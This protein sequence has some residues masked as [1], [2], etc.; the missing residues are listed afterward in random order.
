MRCL[1]CHQET[2]QGYWDLPGGF[3]CALCTLVLHRIRV[4]HPAR[5]QLCLPGLH[6]PDRASP[7]GE[8]PLC[9]H[10]GALVPREETR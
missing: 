3:V 7:P 6:E 1:L 5:V 8:A 10:C 9:R 2:R 4:A